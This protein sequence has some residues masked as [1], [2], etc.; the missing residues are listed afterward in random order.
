MSLKEI[1]NNTEPE[2]SVAMTA[3]DAGKQWA[4]DRALEVLDAMFMEQCSIS[5][6]DWFR[7]SPNLFQGREE[8]IKQVKE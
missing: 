8:F 6:D 2:G 1:Y 3:F 4:L 5:V 7:D